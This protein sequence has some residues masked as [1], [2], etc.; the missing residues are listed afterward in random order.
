V[1]KTV[2]ETPGAEDVMEH[3]AHLGR[4]LWAATHLG[5]PAPVVAQLRDR[6]DQPQP[7]DLVME[8]TPFAS[9]AFDPH[10][11]GRLLQIDARPGWPQLVAM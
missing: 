11:I 2:P 6:M 4:A 1:S 3:I 7:G 9:G 5:A 10:S 8:I